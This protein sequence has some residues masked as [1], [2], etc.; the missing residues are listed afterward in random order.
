M[1]GHPH[2]R[3]IARLEHASV[4]YTLTKHEPVYTSAEAAQVRGTELR[5]GAKALILKADDEFIM[6]VVPADLAIVGPALR[7]HLHVRRLRFATK[8]EL[9]ELTG[10]TPG[11]VP[12][13][14]SLFGLR[15]ACDDRLRD[16]DWINFN[17]ADHAR[18][19]QMRF[20]DYASVES[21]DFASF[22]RADD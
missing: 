22:T 3:L 1:H 13:F 7:K 4:E 17:A 14:G 11:A 6:A 12:P 5:S 19:V 9:L 16:N 8:E 21:P 15:T 2:E 20:V 18:S 10:L